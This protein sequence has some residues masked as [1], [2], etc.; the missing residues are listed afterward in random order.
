MP[1]P[2]S[3]GTHFDEEPLASL[4]ASVRELGVLQP[5][6]VREAGD[7]P[8]RA[9]R[10]RAALAAPA[11]R[12]LAPSRPSCGET[13]DA[14]SL[15]QALVE[16]LHRQDL[17]PLEEAAAYQQLIEDFGLTHDELARR[18][19]KSRSAVTNTL[20]LLQLPR[21]S[22]GSWP[23][24]SCRL[25]TPG[26]ARHAGPRLPGALARRAVEERLSVREVEEAVRAGPGTRDARRAERTPARR[27]RPA[28]GAARAGG[29]A[30]RVPEHEGEGRDGRRRG[31]VVI[32]FATLEDLERIYR[33]ITETSNRRLDNSPL[34]GHAHLGTTLWSI[35]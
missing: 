19:G 21:P 23:T 29:A 22:S 32:E 14:A 26:A 17:N 30:R 33:R 11:Q 7:G 24:A 25:A 10:R 6:L 4:T 16:N 8:L 13:D 5:V 18:V 20:R 27:P 2:T 15:E 35:A 34:Q 9:D 31:P 3:P 28:A 1:N 12:A